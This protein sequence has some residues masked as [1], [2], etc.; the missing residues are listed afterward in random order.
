MQRTAD[1]HDPIADAHFPQAARIMDDAAALDAAVD[2][3]DTYPAACDTPIRR[4]LRPRQGPTPRLLCW[5]DDLDL[6]EREGKKAPI[7]EQ[8][9]A[10]GQGVG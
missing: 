6:V 10:C 4:F 1:F 8:P 7:L 9:T 3:L 2:V 5:H